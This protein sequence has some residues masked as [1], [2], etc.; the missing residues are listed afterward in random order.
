MCFYVLYV[1]VF[2]VC[3]SSCEWMS[4]V[5]F[6]PRGYS[7][8]M[9]CDAFGACSEYVYSEYFQKSS[10]TIA[11]QWKQVTRSR[12]RDR[13]NP[14]WGRNSRAKAEKLTKRREIQTAH[15]RYNH[16]IVLYVT[17]VLPTNTRS[18]LAPPHSHIYG[19]AEG[20]EDHG[21]APDHMRYACANITSLVCDVI[22]GEACNG[23]DFC[24]IHHCWSIQCDCTVCSSWLH[25]NLLST[26]VRSSC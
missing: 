23:S 15:Y 8:M 11:R 12:E 20:E 9:W 18:H 25:F 3:T 7:M 10:K 22:Q 2:V 6:P 14:T 13:A 4:L 5:T 24:Y 19:Q 26:K 1:C 21:Q 17:T 16:S